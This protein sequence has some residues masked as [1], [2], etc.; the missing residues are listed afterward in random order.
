[1]CQTC[2]YISLQ[3][4]AT[5]ELV[6]RDVRFVILILRRLCLS[7]YIHYVFFWMQTKCMVLNLNKYYIERCVKRDVKKTGEDGDWKKK[8][9]D[10]GGWRRIADEA[11]KKLQA[12][13]H[14]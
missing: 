14:P 2:K 4:V 3:N 7:G 13:P 11:L 1:M 12:A 5:N 10:R 9:G 8:T 6:Q